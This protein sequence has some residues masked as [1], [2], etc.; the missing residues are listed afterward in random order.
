MLLL[1]FGFTYAPRQFMRAIACK[2]NDLDYAD[3]IALL[4]NCVEMANCQ[5]AALSKA[6]SAVGLEINVKKTEYMSFSIQHTNPSES[7]ISIDNQQIAHVQ[8]FKYLGAMMSSSIADIKHRKALA[9][10][11][12]WK[13]IEFGKPATFLSNS[14]LTFL[15]P[16]CSL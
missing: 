3:D 9:W 14:K 13:S 1:D 8:D 7:K 5:L 2:R 10:A 16:L 15:R 4:E 6:A 11:A 12:F